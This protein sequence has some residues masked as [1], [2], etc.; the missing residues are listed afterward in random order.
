MVSAIMFRL[1]GPCYG[2]IDR[3]PGN[4]GIAVEESRTRTRRSS[5]RASD[6]QSASHI[7]MIETLRDLLRRKLRTSLTILGITVGTLALTVMGA[8]SEKIN[9][10]VEGANRYYNTRVIVR[11]AASAPGQLFGPPLSVDVARQIAG[12]PGVDVAFPTTYMLYQEEEEEAP[13]ITLGFPP[14]VIGVDARRFEYERDGY[15][16]V[17]SSG[18]LFGPDDRNAAVVGVD[19][20]RAKSVRLGDTLK[21]RGRDFHVVGIIERELTARD[22]IVFVPL[23]D[24]QEL[25]AAMLPPPFDGDPYAIASEIEVFPADLSRADALAEAI[26]RDTQGLRALPPGEME[27]QFRQSLVV[28]NVIVVG[29]AVI[30]LV[31]GG[32]SILNTMATAVTERTREIGIKKAIGASNGDIVWEFLREAVTMGVVGGALGLGLG[33]LLAF[34]INSATVT[35]GVVI[36]AVTLRLGIFVLVFATVLGAAAGLY[37]ALSAARRNPVEALRAE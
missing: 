28:L 7:P 5:P 31:V 16:V 8:M 3:G 22:N 10:L 21:V 20:A 23:A 29:S 15:P 19:L 17:V 34:A 24:A 14:L 12:L 30:A 9:L 35:R 25:M 4:T 18:R 13:S 2:S 6:K 27:R 1:R 26:T 36:F 33:A 32:L 37:P 11:P